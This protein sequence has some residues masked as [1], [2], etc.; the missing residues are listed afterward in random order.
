[1]QIDTQGI[2]PKWERGNGDRRIFRLHAPDV[3]PEN[4]AFFK[5]EVPWKHVLDLPDDQ[6]FGE[7]GTVEEHAPASVV[8]LHERAWINNLLSQTPGGP[9][10]WEPLYDRRVLKI[11][12]CCDVP[13]AVA[14]VSL[15]TA[16]GYAV[17]GQGDSDTVLNLATSHGHSIPADVN[18]PVC[19]MRKF[20][21]PVREARFLFA[22]WES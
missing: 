4:L 21:R 15:A 12:W 9:F 19:L 1:M 17:R 11:A 20:F 8:R 3:R 18:V 13:V 5:G 2:N 6:H 7:L 16:K 22:V 10:V 14:S